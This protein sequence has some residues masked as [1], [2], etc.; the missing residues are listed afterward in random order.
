M[1]RIEKK[2]HFYAGHR[3]EKLKDKCYNLHGHTYYLTMT[4]NLPYDPYSGVTMLFSDIDKLVKPIIKE[5]DHSLLINTYDP[6]C[7]WLHRFMEE[8]EEELKLVKFDNSTSAE[9][10]A[11]WIFQRVKELL[12]IEKITLQETTSSIVTYEE[13]NKD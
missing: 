6:L 10:L 2:Y 3:N 4:F 12:P 1:Y 5:L 7:K 11:K 9:N 13:Q 8:E